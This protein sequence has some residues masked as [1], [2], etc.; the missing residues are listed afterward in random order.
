MRSHDGSIWV[1]SNGG[2]FRFYNGAWLENAA[3]GDL[4]DG[5]VHAIFEDEHSRLWAATADGLRVF[6][7]EADAGP[8]KTFL[9]SAGGEGGQLSVF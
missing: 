2:L 5:P 7:R 1:A 9:R 4:P 3:G 8:P 6:H